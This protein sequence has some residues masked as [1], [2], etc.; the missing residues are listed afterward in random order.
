MELWQKPT[1]D[2]LMQSEATSSATYLISADWTITE[3][4]KL[5]YK[6]TLEDGEVDVYW[7]NTMGR[8]FLYEQLIFHKEE[9]ATV[10]VYQSTSFIKSKGRGRAVTIT[11][12]TSFTNS[13]PLPLQYWN[14][15]SVWKLQFC[16]M[17]FLISVKQA[18][19]AYG[20]LG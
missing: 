6:I 9:F 8:E 1:G 20:Y 12:S 2:K 7:L 14:Y 15:G 4:C 16:C 10:W 18:C 5:S 11:A 3:S 17:V 19:G 13:I